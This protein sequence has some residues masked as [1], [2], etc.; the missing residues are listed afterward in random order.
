MVVDRYSSDA[1]ELWLARQ[2]QRRW[3]PQRREH[4]GLPLHSVRC[5]EKLGRRDHL[6]DGDF[7]PLCKSHAM[8]S[9]YVTDY[10]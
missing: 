9:E 3:R 1:R 2:H 5:L 10:Q 6:S 8:P 4:V 7:W